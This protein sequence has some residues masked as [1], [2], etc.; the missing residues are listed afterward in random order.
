MIQS[1]SFL[2]D[3]FSTDFSLELPVA[4]KAAFACAKI[5]PLVCP[6]CPKTAEQPSKCA[7]ESP[8]RTAVLKAHS[9]APAFENYVK[10]MN[11]EW[12]APSTDRKLSPDSGLDSQSAD[13]WDEQPAEWDDEDERRSTDTEDDYVP[14]WQRN[15]PSYRPPR[16]WYDDPEDKEDKK[17]LILDHPMNADW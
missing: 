12:D 16:R 17:P 15:D 3:V 8:S 11:D 5:R 13:L 7:V 9:Q 6:L 10:A 1:L 2:A 14:H 4:S